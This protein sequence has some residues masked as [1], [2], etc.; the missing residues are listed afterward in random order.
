MIRRNDQGVALAPKGGSRDC[1][2]IGGAHGGTLKSK[3]IA[4]SGLSLF[5]ELNKVGSQIRCAGPIT[6]FQQC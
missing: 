4:N 3:R 2:S 1:K 5:I 6:A